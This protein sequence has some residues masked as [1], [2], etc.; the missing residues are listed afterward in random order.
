MI[1]PLSAYL[2]YE[3]RTVSRLQTIAEVAGIFMAVSCLHTPRNTLTCA[4]Q[5][6]LVVHLMTETTV[7]ILLAPRCTA[8]R[9]QLLLN[10]VDNVNLVRQMLGHAGSTL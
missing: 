8:R 3:H 1:Q 9:D 5:S 4:L 6:L 10:G 2:H 7:H